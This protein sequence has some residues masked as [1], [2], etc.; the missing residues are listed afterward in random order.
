[1]DQ[2]GAPFE[3]FD[4]IM[5]DLET[6]GLNPRAPVAAIGAVR[7][8]RA[9]RQLGAQFYQVVDLRS[10]DKYPEFELNF[11]TLRWWLGQQDHVIKATFCHEKALPLAEALIAFGQ[12]CNP[13]YVS[14]EAPGF[15][16][17]DRVWGN[18]SDFDNVILGHA[19]SA[20][21]CYLPWK[22][23]NNR[24][25]R[26]MKN[27]APNVRIVRTGDHHNAL[28]DAISQANHLLAIDEA[29]RS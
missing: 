15:V 26:T 20:A 27:E 14:A 8:N 29:I 12:Y 19:Y 10:Y 9:T 13:N 16:T 18:G 3:G 17:D 24:C 7:M 21:K 6:L 1:M 25:Y 28:S 2:P 4:D 11:A 5:V 22:W 23:F